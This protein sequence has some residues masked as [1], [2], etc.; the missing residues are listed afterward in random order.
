L[1]DFAIFPPEPAARYSPSSGLYTTLKM[2]DDPKVLFPTA[3]HDAG[4]KG[5]GI[6]EV[7]A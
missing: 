4:V 1:I 2:F 6:V 5:K 7:T 3:V